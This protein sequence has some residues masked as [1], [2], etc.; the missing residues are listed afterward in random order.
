MSVRR[1][2][3]LARGIAVFA[4]G[5][6]AAFCAWGDATSLTLSAGSDNAGPTP[7]T[8]LFPLSRGGDTSYDAYLS[9]Q[10]QDGTAVAGT[11]YTAASGVLRIPAGSTSASIPVSISAQTADGPSKTFQMLVLGAAGIGA[12]A[13]FAN[14]AD[15]GVTN[16]PY[17]VATADFNGDGKPDVVATNIGGT[18]I[19][20]LLNTTPA[21]ATTPSFATAVDIGVGSNPSQLVVADFN[22][23]GKPD[24]ALA[25][26]GYSAQVTVLLNT[27]PQ[28]A[29][30]PTFSS[31][32]FATGN[33]PNQIAVADFNGD[34]KPDLAVANA[35]GGG[36]GDFYVSLLINSTTPGASSASF[37]LVSGPDLGNG[38]N[39]TSMAV[40]DFN[41]D[42]KPDLAVA[43]ATG[44]ASN[45]PVQVFLN[46][47][48]GGAASF[49][50][51]QP[52]F[53]GANAS[54]IAVADFNG[55]GKPDM[56]V[57]NPGAN[58]SAGTVS[59]MINGTATGSATA[60]FT[61]AASPAV[62]DVSGVVTGDFNGD[63]KPDI[64]VT[65]SDSAQ[66]L[67]NTTAPG[68][69]TP[70]FEPQSSFPVQLSPFNLAAAD[71]NGDGRLDL[72]AVNFYSN[73][74]TVLLNTGAAP[75][76]VPQF[77]LA[78][79]PVAGNSPGGVGAA[80][81][82]GDGLPDLAV[83]NTNSG[84]V[85][86]FFNGTAPGAAAGVFN[87]ASAGSPLI[88]SY[89]GPG[90]MVI[91]DFN[92]DGKPDIAV[93]DFT[94]NVDPG[95]ASVFINGTTPGSASASFT[96]SAE[97]T[98]DGAP[99][100]IAAADM[101]GDGKLDLVV[102]S[103][104]N[105]SS[106]NASRVSVVLG[107]GDGSF[108]AQQ[109][110]VVGTGLSL[111]GVAV[112]DVN[113]DG[114]PDIL[115]ANSLDN[116][117]D[118][119]VL[120]NTTPAGSSTMSFAAP[121][122]F[123]TGIHTN[124]VAV[125][126]FN[127]DGI[128]DI[129]VSGINEGTG[130]GAVVTFINTTTVSGGVSS[131]GL[132]SIATT[133]VGNYPQG[134]VVK[135]FDGDGRL[136][137]AVINSADNTVSVL[138]NHTAAGAATT[139]FVPAATIYSTGNNPSQLASADFNGDGK[140]DL[141]SSNIG[142]SNATVLFNT[143]YQVATGGS[144]AT[145]TIVFAAPQAPINLAVTGTGPGQVSLSWTG[146]GG[147]TDYY[148]YFGDTPG[149]ENIK[150]AA[151]VGTSTTITGLNGGSTYYFVVKAY[152]HGSEVLS[153]ASNEVSVTTP[154]AAPANLL[155]T[156]GTAQV[157][158]SWT[159]SAG[160]SDYYVFYGTS[161]GGE[162]TKSPAVVGTSTTLSLSSGVTYYFVVKAYNHANAITSPASN[163]VSA[164]PE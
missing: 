136:D 11:D 9:Y 57:S 94:E 132:G 105:R 128:P 38:N 56:A 58:F 88:V 28:G 100:G 102:S 78:A 92:N 112:A 55:D 108:Q 44:N 80:D 33:S 93:A 15:F 101:N 145:G 81:F 36:T 133:V 144:P 16:E 97:P 104:A 65:A 158:L 120:L 159:A 151:I 19:S 66:V 68:A 91:G 99:Y 86:V 26:N 43:V 129:A 122:S 130:T 32:T 160:A 52:F 39:P 4:G 1:F 85:S 154:L 155:A 162:T 50:A 96:L 25:F 46:T 60:S 79:A 153:A 24:I 67:I 152:N 51:S 121:L 23:D 75:A 109:E 61:L 40:A 106:D 117:S 54:T 150:S 42:G 72:V 113:G 116:G 143:Q 5:L 14:G 98:V 149:G 69:A 103:G 71:F 142:S 3:A 12:P 134:L 30:T 89:Y 90:P 146:A 53:A 49:G 63:G 137:L 48:T 138:Y 10:T 114:R 140:P 156:A 45:G 123:S 141:V 7:T 135:D 127:G 31:Q 163:E 95:Y 35:A 62:G 77:T 110:I 73:S 8:L 13:S 17:A 21:G 22:G 87:A 148:V 41:G 161:S 2:G 70:S 64:A 59:V 82:N 126:D 147:A 74:A 107:N 119:Y 111:N 125:G 164:T 47:S 20:I 27:T 34:G 157:S 118:L 37:N 29:A 115:V 131:F 6:G 139:N 76:S 124:D 18:T 84:T 83:A